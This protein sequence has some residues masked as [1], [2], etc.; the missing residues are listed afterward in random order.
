MV[1]VRVETK[2]DLAG[3]WFFDPQPLRPD[4]HPTIGADL[5]GRAH[6]PHIGPP[7]AAR[8]GSQHRTIF[9][10]RLVP[11]SLWDLAQLTMD[12]VRVAMR[13][14]GVDVPVGFSIVVIFSLA[15]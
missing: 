14:Q 1:A 10:L 3:R 2:H 6:A 5:E 12:F 7:R 9:F 4:G 11:G 8:G 13:P 15:K